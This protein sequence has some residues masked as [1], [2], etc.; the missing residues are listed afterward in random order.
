M[1]NRSMGLALYHPNMND[2]TVDLLPHELQLMINSR[3]ILLIIPSHS[4]GIA[5]S[6]LA[7]YLIGLRTKLVLCVKL[8]PNGVTISGEQV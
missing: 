3:V 6:A 5:I 8:I 1:I 4:R 2:Y 7:A